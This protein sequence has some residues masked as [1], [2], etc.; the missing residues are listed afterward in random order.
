M[1]VSVALAWAVRLFNE[2]L[3]V[4][5]SKKFAAALWRV[6]LFT[7]VLWAAGM[8]GASSG[9]ATSAEIDR[10]IAAAMGPVLQQLEEINEKLTLNDENQRKLLMAA[11]SDKIRD[12]QKICMSTRPDTIE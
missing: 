6:F 5:E 4:A 10:R 9:F 11:V 3:T 1:P 8:L 12:L 2:G 7:S